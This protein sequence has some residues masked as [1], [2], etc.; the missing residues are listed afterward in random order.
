MTEIELRVVQEIEGQN[1]LEQEIFERKEVEKE[2]EAQSVELKENLEELVLEIKH[3]I[4]IEKELIGAKIFAETANKAKDNFLANISHEIRTPMNAIIGYSQLLHLAKTNNDREGFISLINKGGENLLHII[5]D[6]LDISIINA[7]K[8][9]L[10]RVR[11]DLLEVIDETINLIEFKRREKNIT[12]DRYVNDNVEKIYFDDVGV[13]RQILLNIAGNAI[14]FTEQGGVSISVDLLEIQADRSLIQF[15][16]KDTGIGLS[17]DF[18]ER[19]FLPYTQ[20][21]E[22]NTRTYGG[23][24]LGLAITKGLIEKLDGNIMIESEKQVGTTVTFKI[25][26]SNVTG[27]EKDESEEGIV[28]ELTTLSDEHRILIVEDDFQSRNLY[29]TFFEQ[30][31]FDYDIAENGPETIEMFRNNKYDLVLMDI[32]LPGQ[33]GFELTEILLKDNPTISVVAVSAHAFIEHKERAKDVGMI[34]FITKPIDYN[35]LA[36]KLRKYLS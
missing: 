34:D 7:H 3:R 1:K 4:K 21:N 20:E 22:S 36:D 13:V 14:K 11:F 26:L 18:V 33:D 8:K 35:K 2:L 31:G 32:Q 16:V 28:E 24:G 27:L 23:I 29:K 15:V 12:V 25:F 30:E 19:A 5:D 9:V 6:I 10:H 17:E